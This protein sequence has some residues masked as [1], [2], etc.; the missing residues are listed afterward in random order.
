MPLDADGHL[1]T[2]SGCA[3]LAGQQRENERTILQERA[4]LDQL[5][6]G[7]NDSGSQS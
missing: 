7:L 2:G 4:E 6:V 3:G 5:Q 1:L